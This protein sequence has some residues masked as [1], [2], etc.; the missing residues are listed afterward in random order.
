M[1]T[2]EMLQCTTFQST[3]PHGVRRGLSKGR[4]VVYEFQ[5]TYPHGVRLVLLRTLGMPGHFNPRTR[6]GYDMKSVPTVAAISISIHVPARGT[7]RTLR[8]PHPR[9]RFQST[10]PHGVRHSG[11]G[12]RTTGGYFNPRTRTG[13]D[14]AAL[15]VNRYISIFQST[16]PH[17]VRHEI[18]PRTPSGMKFQSTYPH[19]VR[20]AMLGWICWTM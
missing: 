8:L 7:T 20:H 10:Y 1:G 9:Y 2:N 4:N 16:Y 6:T 11:Q 15:L 12:K 18:H 14:A 3:Y 17:G 13:Y 5:S 19:G